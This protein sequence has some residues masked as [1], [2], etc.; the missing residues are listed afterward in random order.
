[1][2]AILEREFQELRDAG[3]KPTTGDIRCAA[4]GHITRMAIWRLRSSWD[5]KL[6]TETKLSLFRD[7]MDALANLDSVIRLL[8]KSEATERPNRRLA[9]METN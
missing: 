3:M 9:L 4:Y 8:D 5:Q 2:A 6:P 7:A 1:L